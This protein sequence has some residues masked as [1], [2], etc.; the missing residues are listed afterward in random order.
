[1]VRTGFNTKV[2]VGSDWGVV[3]FYDPDGTK[4]AGDDSWTE[5]YEYKFTIG[6]NGKPEISRGAHVGGKVGFVIFNNPSCYL[7]DMFIENNG[8]VESSNLVLSSNY[9]YP[10]P[11]A[12]KPFEM[13]GNRMV[14]VWTN[15]VVPIKFGVTYSV[16]SQNGRQRFYSGS[17]VLLDLHEQTTVSLNVGTNGF[18]TVTYEGPSGATNIGYMKFINP[19][20]SA[21]T[22]SVKDGGYE[23]S[24]IVRGNSS[25]I[26]IPWGATPYE[27]GANGVKFIIEDPSA[28]TPPPE[29]E[30]AEDED[31]EDED[32]EDEDAEDEDAED[33]DAEDEDAEDEDDDDDDAEGETNSIPTTLWVTMSLAAV[34]LLISA[35]SMRKGRE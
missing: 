22:Y 24:E 1:M 7:A 8:Y 15:T 20:A 33:E 13:K 35:G 5:G 25:Y 34:A 18:F 3:S 11:W 27:P 2:Y 28:A 26:R 30:D 16:A 17:T 14:I 12:K 23:T 6:V 4:I 10:I 32:A 31:A 9:M 29:D 21:I 19:N